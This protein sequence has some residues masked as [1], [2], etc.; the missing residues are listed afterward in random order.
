V[1]QI[2]NVIT[3][4]VN[5]NQN[6]KV[7]RIQDVDLNVCL[8]MTVLEIRPVYKI[9]AKILVL[10]LV[11]QMQSVKYIITYLCVDALMECREMPLL[12]VWFNMVC[13]KVK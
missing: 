1:V 7:I 10:E 11:E 6:S 3:V 12:T 5:A 4:F 9:N 13:L 8:T 2:L